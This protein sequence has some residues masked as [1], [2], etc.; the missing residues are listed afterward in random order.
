MEGKLQALLCGSARGRQYW[1][2]YRAHFGAVEHMFH[3]IPRLHATW[4]KIPRDELMEAVQS[5]ILD[6][7]SKIPATLGP[8]D[9][10]KVMESLR[11]ALTPY[12]DGH[13]DL[14]RQASA[15]CADITANVGASWR[16][17]FRDK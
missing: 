13:A 4:L 1:Y 7:D 17:A 9:T 8:L 5:G 3:I 15:L 14:P 10:A 6:P 11:D 2:A 16:D 12:I